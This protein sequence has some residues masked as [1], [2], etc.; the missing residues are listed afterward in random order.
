MSFLAPLFLL[1]AAAVLAPILLHLIRRQSQSEQVF[2]SLMF[3]EPSPPTMIRRSRVDQWLLL[4]LRTG[5]ILLLVSAFARPFWRAGIESIS[6]KPQLTRAILLDT[7]A[8]MSRALIWDQAKSTVRQIVEDSANESPVALYAFDHSLKPIVSIESLSEQNKP[9]NVA[10]VLKAL[11]ELEPTSFASNLGSA[12]TSLSDILTKVETASSKNERRESEIVIVT[13]FQAGS[14]ISALENYQW[15]H[16]CRVSIKRLSRA[17]SNVAANVI[18]TND[19]KNHL[20]RLQQRGGTTNRPVELMWLDEK[21]KPIVDSPPVKVDVP[22][23]GIT[24]VQIPRPSNPSSI[25]QVRGD[26]DEF[27]NRRWIARAPPRPIQILCF[28]EENTPIEKSLTFFLKQMPF[29][30]LD[31]AVTFTDRKPNSPEAWPSSKEAPWIVADH[32]LTF[33]DAE[34]I[35]GLVKSGSHLLLVL[36]SILDESQ[37]SE[38]AR[39]LSNLSGSAVSIREAESHKDVILE[40]VD[41]KHSLFQPLAE[42]RFNDFTKIR[43]WK[44]RIVDLESIS[45]SK[46]V[47]RFDDGSPALAYF[48]IEKGEV[49]LLTSGWQPDES[50]LALSSKFVP[51]ISQLFAN[52]LPPRPS[53]QDL[54]VGDSLAIEPNEVW[55][56]AEQQPIPT[57]SE[58]DGRRTIRFDAPGFYQR[59]V[60]GESHAVAVN[61]SPSESDTREMEVEKIER[62]GVVTGVKPV[63]SERLADIE[64][65]KK[66]AE[67][68]KDQ[69]LWRWFMIGMLGFLAVETI[70]AARK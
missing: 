27:D 37:S 30:S 8:S 22:I 32:S 29:E 23:E 9:D 21:A 50:Q 49:W 46:T 35:K 11:N 6:A 25:L 31:Y 54:R 69:R 51:I 60:D 44:H 34:S 66:N 14:E 15:P 42:S 70:Y 33:A 59:T 53:L 10:I 13:D 43:F 16:N 57:I 56:D 40:K 52:A 4:F 12:L 36:D 48:P 7:S 64:R 67:L 1:G 18:E 17:S 55:L 68:E 45:N 39:V 65:R 61:L 3:L 2:S 47:A 28:D 63:E 5:V 26:D 58:R 41:F 19:P 24:S 62:L 20:V 38:A